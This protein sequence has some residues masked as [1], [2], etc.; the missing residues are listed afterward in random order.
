MTL[1]PESLHDTAEHAGVEAVG[2]QSGEGSCPAHALSRRGLLRTAAVAGTVATAGAGLSACSSL[3]KSNDGTAA[4][5]SVDTTMASSAP[6]TAA[7]MPAQTV[8]SQP[9]MTSSSAAAETHASGTLLG[10]SS[11]IPEGGGVIYSAHHVVVTQPSAGMYKAFS[12]VC[13]HAGCQCNQ[14]TS[15]QI[16]CPCHNAVFSISDGSPVSGPAHSA[17]ESRTVTVQNGEVRL[18]A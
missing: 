10:H 8:S 9:A 7:A 3:F 12:T 16:V 6:S 13:P 18:Q 4:A 2:C 1:T 14:V 17:L 5:G 11:E 15:G